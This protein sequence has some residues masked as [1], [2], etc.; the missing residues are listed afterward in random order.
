MMFSAQRV[1]KFTEAVSRTALL[2]RL[3]AGLQADGLVK[4]SFSR[5][6]AGAGKGLS[7]GDFY[8]DPQRRHPAYRV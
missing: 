5:R 8:G 3:A 1:V 6:G 4:P 7:D 2:T